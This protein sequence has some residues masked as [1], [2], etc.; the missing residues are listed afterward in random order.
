M[1]DIGRISWTDTLI[2]G[3]YFFTVITIISD[4]LVDLN[5]KIL[6]NI[7]EIYCYE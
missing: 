7:K 6:S 1:T 2:F 3:L 5:P 4:L